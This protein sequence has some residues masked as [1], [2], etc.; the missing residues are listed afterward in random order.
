MAGERNH[1]PAG[2]TEQLFQLRFPGPENYTRD[3]NP[4]S[5]S[6]NDRLIKDDQKSDCNFT[7][8]HSHSSDLILHTDTDDRG[9]ATITRLAHYPVKCR[10]AGNHYGKSVVSNN[11]KLHII[12]YHCLVFM[13]ALSGRVFYQVSMLPI[14]AAPISSLHIPNHGLFYVPK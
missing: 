3:Q 10:N 8:R 9:K 4:I 1:P 6:G 7:I 14:S 11:R 13:T 5:Q 2:S 12:D